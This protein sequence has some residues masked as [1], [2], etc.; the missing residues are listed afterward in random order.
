MLRD[1]SRAGNARKTFVQA[2]VDSPTDQEL[3]FFRVIQTNFDNPIFLHHFDAKRPLYMNV[4]ASK[5]YGFE[6]IVYH[7]ERDPE[8]STVLSDGKV[9]EFS[10]TRIQS[11]LFLSKLLSTAKQNYWPTEL[12]V[13]GLV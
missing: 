4:D 7:V 5:K 1:S 2:I 13:A 10:R 3:K 12:E 8:I 9:M 11:V 6:S